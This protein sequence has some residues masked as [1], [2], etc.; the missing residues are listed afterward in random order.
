MR[1]NFAI[2]FYTAFMMAIVM[3]LFIWSNL[4]SEFL[5]GNGM[6]KVEFAC[7]LAGVT[8][9]YV[10][11]FSILHTSNIRLDVVILSSILGYF[12]IAF[13][14]PFYIRVALKARDQSH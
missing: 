5:L 13:V 4:H 9:K 14:A 2:E 3:L 10:F 8:V 12:F 11:L 1:E 6:L 7:V